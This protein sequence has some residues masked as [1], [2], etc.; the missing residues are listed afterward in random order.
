MTWPPRIGTRTHA[1][2]PAELRI[3]IVAF[4]SYRELPDACFTSLGGREAAK[5]MHKKLKATR[6]AAHSLA[7]PGAAPQESAST[8]ASDVTDGGAGAVPGSQSAPSSSTTRE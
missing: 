4:S 6:K 8:V 3:K 2:A 1:C 5:V 7:A